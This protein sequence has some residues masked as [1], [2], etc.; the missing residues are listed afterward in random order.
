[1]DNS[2]DK[3]MCSL[4]GGHVDANERC[5]PVVVLMLKKDMRQA[6]WKNVNSTNPSHI[7]RMGKNF[8]FPTKVRYPL[9]FL[10]N[11]EVCRLLGPSFYEYLLSVIM[12]DH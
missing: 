4:S 3:L 12:C 10:G 8:I 11:S 1:M 2:A 5:G 9:I 7:L 6:L